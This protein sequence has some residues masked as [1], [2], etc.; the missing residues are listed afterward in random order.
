MTSE[1]KAP[2]RSW[3]EKEDAALVEAGFEQDEERGL[4]LK[5]GILLGRGAALQL[6]MLEL[7]KSSL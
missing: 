4:W 3:Q 2:L 5:S 6:A 1:E 7:G